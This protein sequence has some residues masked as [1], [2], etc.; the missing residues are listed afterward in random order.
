MKTMESFSEMLTAGG[1]ANSLGRTSEVI[2]IVQ[3][4]TKRLNELFGCIFNDDAWV[5]M[6]AIDGF[7]KIIRE[8]PLLVQPYLKDIFTK[9]T[10]SEQASIQ[11]HLAQIFVTADLNEAQERQAIAWLTNKLHSTDIDWIVSIDSMKALLHFYENAVVDK[12]TL[13]EV[14]TIQTKHKSKTV[15][16]KATQFQIEL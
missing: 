10:K 6:R 14:F 1:H 9:L 16:K 7:E 2:E 3:N 11:W 13:L 15:R 5:R 8:R 12:K 4:D